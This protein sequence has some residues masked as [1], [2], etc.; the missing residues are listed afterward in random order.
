MKKTL[1]LLGTVAISLMLILTGCRSEESELIESPENE[2]LEAN[3]RVADL[4]QRT[5]QNDGSEDN[6]IDGASC[7]D[8]ELPVTVNVNGLEI[9]VDSEDDLDLIE[10]IFDEFEDDEDELEIFFP[11]T[12]VLADF[13]E[14]VLE[15]P[16]QLEDFAED[17]GGENGRRE[18]ES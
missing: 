13:T 16:D 15:N 12:I 11:I 17:C 4:L 2:T 3:S 14:V 10:E 1:K 9:T 8:I 5:A 6:I 18:K 7:F